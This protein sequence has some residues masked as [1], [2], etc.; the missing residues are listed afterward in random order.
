VEDVF[1]L[2]ESQ[3]VYVQQSQKQRQFLTKLPVSPYSSDLSKGKSQPIPLM[4]EYDK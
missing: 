3:R 4:L 2:M 1:S